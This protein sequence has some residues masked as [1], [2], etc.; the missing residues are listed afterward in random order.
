MKQ[1]IAYDE[2]RGEF[3]FESAKLNTIE[4]ISLEMIHK[5]IYIRFVLLFFSFA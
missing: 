3:G 4:I 1:R 5:V 2:G